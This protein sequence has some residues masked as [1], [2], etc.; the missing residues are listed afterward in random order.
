VF[1]YGM[2]LDRIIPILYVI[3]VTGFTGYVWAYAFKKTK[4]IAVGLGLHLGFNLVMI[5]FYPSQPYGELL[6]TELSRVELGE[7]NGF[8]YS[9]FK[10]LFPSILTL[11]FLKLL[12]RSNFMAFK[13]HE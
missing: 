4:S 8:Y 7:W 2:A 5:C 6:F 13:N 9:L 12:L 11:I 1:S 10:G 3:L